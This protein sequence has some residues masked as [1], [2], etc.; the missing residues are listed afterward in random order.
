MDLLPAIIDMEETG[1]PIDEEVL[2]GLGKEFKAEMARH[3]IAINDA[4]GY[5]INLNANRQLAELVYGTLGHKCTV[6][7]EKTQQPST[8]AATLAVFSKDPV[9]AHIQEH[10]KLSKLQSTFIEGI[11]R[12]TFE[13]RVHPSFNQV[14]A[15]SGR[16]S[17]S[18]P[19]IQQIPSR[20]ERGKRLRECFVAGHKKI[21]VVADLSQIELRVLAHFTQDPILLKVYREAGASLHKLLAAEVFGPDYTPEQYAYAKNGN[22][23]CLFGAQAKTLVLKYDFPN[24]R[25]AQRVLDGFYSTYKYVQPWKDTVI[26]ES[27]HRNPCH[28]QTILGRKRRLPE[29]ASLNRGKRSAAERQAISVRVSGSAADLFKL[30]MTQC[31]NRLQAQKFPAHI[32]MTIHDEMVVE[33]PA[34]YGEETLAIVKDSMENI[35]NPLTHEPILTVPIIAE[36]KIVERW[37]DGK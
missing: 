6:F 17:C 23:S 10:A 34:R 33:A 22:F 5:D 18:E 24:E 32:L 31:H 16:V 30:A 7:S 14:G 35:I 1:T 15:V 9:I 11:T 29:L 2:A 3:K 21:L 27:F 12:N 36:G 19:N 8:A 26:H 28:V 37:S 25:T 13:G 4:A 20:T